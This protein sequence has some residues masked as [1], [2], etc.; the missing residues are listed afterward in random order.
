M[1]KHQGVDFTRRN[2]PCRHDRFSESGRGGQDAVLVGNHG[3]S[4]DLLVGAKLAV[5]H[6]INR[7]TGESLVVEFYSNLVR[8]EER[9]DFSKTTARQG[10][11][12]GKFLRATND[13]R[14]AERGQSHRLRAIE[15]RVLKCGEPVQ[16][17]QHRGRQSF[18][19]NKDQ[20][21]TNNAHFRWQ[22][23]GDGFVLFLPGRRQRPRVV[24]LFIVRDT[25]PN[26]DD[27]SATFGLLHHVFDFGK[28]HPPDARQQR[29]LVGVW[30]KLSI[31]KYAVA[32]ATRHVLQ[33]QCDEIAKASFGHRVLTRKEAVVGIETK[34]IPPLHCPGE[35]GCAE[36]SGEAGRQWCFKKNPDV[37]AA[38]GA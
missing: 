2:Q 18:L 28:C 9:R 21:A 1:H 24:R 26:T 15:F 19:F 7:L 37:T 34:L 10:D 31:E 23:T 16:T 8:F 30:I 12:L 4:C 13:A 5:K 33:R 36:S 25:A 20:V 17:I 32:V 27:V 29:P 35:N 38:P 3:V 11:M 14:F 22:R 6:H